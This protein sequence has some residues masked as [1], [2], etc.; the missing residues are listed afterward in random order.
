MGQASMLPHDASQAVHAAHARAMRLAHVTIFA[1]VASS[2]IALRFDRARFVHAYF[3]AF[4]A[5]WT[6]ALGGLF[7]TL[8]HHVLGAR[9]SVATT[10]RTRPLVAL[11]PWCALLFVP[12]VFWARDIFPWMLR[13]SEQ[14]PHS[15]HFATY[16]QLPSFTV[17]ASVYWLIWLVLAS[18][19]GGRNLQIGGTNESPFARR[20][21]GPALVLFAFTTTFASFDWF[22]SIQPNWHSAV[23]GV[24]L[25]AGA[26]P[27][28]LAF[29]ATLTVVLE[30]IRLLSTQLNTNTRH[31][32]G[33]LLFGFVVFWAYIAFSQYLLIWYAGLASETPFFRTRFNHDWLPT[34]LLLFGL[35]FVLPFIGLLSATAKRSPAVLGAVSLIVLAAHVVDLFWLVMPALESRRSHFCFADIPAVLML[36]CALLILLAKGIEAELRWPESKM[37]AA[38]IEPVHTHFKSTA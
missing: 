30:R 15:L 12:V 16:F 10:R 27:S 31:D 23:F 8:L 13:T 14:T 3:V 9:W 7:L 24:Y 2:V 6:L 17:R 11:L 33:K 21:S 20:L 25:F 4:G 29:L 36:A 22:M 32:I 38:P 5:L 19:Y 26:V 28:A 18:I 1:C 34:T 37:A 35:H